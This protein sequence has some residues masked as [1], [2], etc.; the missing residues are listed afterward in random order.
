MIQVGE[1][2]LTHFGEGACLLCNKWDPKGIDAHNGKR[3]RSH[4]G[5]HLQELAREAIPLSI[6]GLEVRDSRSDGGSVSEDSQEARSS[7][8]PDANSMRPEEETTAFKEATVAEKQQEEAR[9][10][11]NQ[12]QE[13]D[14]PQQPDFTEIKG[15]YEEAMALLK[16]NSVP[17]M[18]QEA[19]NEAAERQREPKEEG[20]KLVEEA[21]KTHLELTIKTEAEV[22]AAAA[23]NEARKV[24]ALKKAEEN[25]RKTQIF[26]EAAPDGPE[27]WQKYSPTGLIESGE[28]KWIEKAPIKFKDAVGRKFSFPFHLCS[29]WLVGLGNV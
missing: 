26:K 27:E 13:G 25:W 24:A 12:I 28:N 21:A 11:E 20:H 1:Q 5:K 14:T 15:H 16:D 7:I 23:K 9:A 18:K 17:H 29:T 19:E 3:F 4:V 10:L 6:D 22:R 8:P 2:P